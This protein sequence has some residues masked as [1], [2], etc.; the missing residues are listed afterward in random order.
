MKKVAL[1]AALA[2]MTVGSAAHA[3]N[4]SLYGLTDMFVGQLKTGGASATVADSGGMS[5]S[6]F[7]FGGSEDLGGGLKA[8]FAVESFMRMDVGAGGRFGAGASGDPLFTRNAY[9]GL[10]NAMGRVAFGRQTTPYFL[11]TIIYNPFGDSFVFSPAV[12]QTFR[13]YI[14]GDSGWNNSLSYSGSFGPVRAYLLY[15]LGLERFNNATNNSA[16]R[17]FGGNLDYSTGPLSLNAA[18][19]TFDSP[20]G[21]PEVI[22][23]QSAMLLSAAYNLS[24]ARLTGQYQQIKGDTTGLATKKDNSYQLGAS[25]KAGPGNVLVSFGNVKTTQSGAADVK[26]DTFAIGYDYFLSKRTDLYANYYQTKL[27]TSSN[28]DTAIGAGI[29]HKF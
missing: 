4:A 8:V 23:K 7:G 29:R 28:T 6:Y 24:M 17:A 12:Q 2:A 27:S 22:T 1:A 25:I 16:N 10:E 5:T 15:S 19:Q 13:G 20:G 26:R 21:T 9:I 11:S 14:L 18:Y 3:Q